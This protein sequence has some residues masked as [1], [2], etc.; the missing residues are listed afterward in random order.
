MIYFQ[1]WADAF[2]GN[3]ALAGVVEVYD[4]LK[5]KGVEFPPL[6]FD[7]LAPI[8]TPRRVNF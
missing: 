3:P 7:L 1:C 5:S 6:D 8:L 4:E 2:R